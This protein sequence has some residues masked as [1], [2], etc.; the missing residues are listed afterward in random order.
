MAGVIGGI[1]GALALILLA[2]FLLWWRRRKASRR[3]KDG[4]VSFTEGLNRFD[5]SVVSISKANVAV[6]ATDFRRH[7]PPSSPI[8][9]DTPPIY[10]SEQ[11]PSWPLS[12]QTSGDYRGVG[13]GPALVPSFVA[14]S[15]DHSQVDTGTSDFHVDSGPYSTHLSAFHLPTRSQIH[16]QTYRT[17][18]GPNIYT[19]SFYAATFDKPHTFDDAIN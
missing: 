19:N 9:N 18:K 7:I 5:D 3:W 1:L 11:S 4:N 17:T 6:T 14:D 16:T 12:A 13:L 15:E 8:H 2:A 10:H